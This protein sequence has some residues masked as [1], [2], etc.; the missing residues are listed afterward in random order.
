MHGLPAD[1]PAYAEDGILGKNILLQPVVP[2]YD[3]MGNFA[4]GKTGAINQSNPLKF[5][6][7]HQDDVT[8]VNQVFGNVFAGFDIMPELAFRSTLGF[9]LSQNS[10]VQF[11]PAF[12]ENAEATFTSGLL[13][14]RNHFTDW[15]LT[16]TL[17][18][19]R[20]FFDQHTVN[21]LVGQEANASNNRFIEGGCGALLNTGTDS[22]YIQDALCSRNPAA[23]TGGRSALLSFFGKVDYNFADL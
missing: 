18:F 22:R 20:S 5:A 6:A 12:P 3:L 1:P 8:R 23:S 19:G 11:N 17:R 7:A 16:N 4:G 2:V 15:T 9:N 13:E 21:V 14:N 10:F